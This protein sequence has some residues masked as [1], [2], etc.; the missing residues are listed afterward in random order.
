MISRMSIMSLVLCLLMGDLLAAEQPK[1]KAGP[2][3]IVMLSWSLEYK[4]DASLKV[5]K[6]YLEKRYDVHCTILSQQK[7]DELPGLEVL[8]DC[9]VLIPFMRRS[10]IKG[11]QLERVK[12]Y[13]LAGKPVVGV[14]TA[15]HAFQNWL[16]LDK[17]VFGGNYKGHYGK[18][19]PCRI[20]V[21]PK[22]KGHP[23]L[24]GVMLTETHGSLYR[25]AG[26]AED[27]QVLLHGT[28]PDHTEPVAWTRIYKKGRI[29][30]TSLGHP[31]DFAN[32]GFLRMMANA[33]FWVSGREATP[34][35][36]P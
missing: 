21:D 17:E 3:K 27:T 29:F 18:E 8:D 26:L 11:E 34:R 13:C 24:A 10:M 15:C 2:L 9:D 33:I 36:K 32:E 31:D 28:I 20:T 25:N 14:R 7:K 30:N 4:S 12:K 6:D 19:E 5:L 16:A 35:S 1:P 23:I 22:G